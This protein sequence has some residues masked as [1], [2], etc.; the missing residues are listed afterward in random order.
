MIRPLLEYADIIFDGSTDTDLDRLESTQRQAA[1]ACSAAYKHTSH[2]KLLEELAWPLLSRRRKNHR[3]NL[4]HKIQNDLVPPYLRNSCPPLT[5]NRT[6][7]NLR[8]NMNISTPPQR[9][10]T[11]QNSFFPKTIKD[12][13]NLDRSTRLLTSTLNFKEFLKN[14]TTKKPNKL[15]HHDSSKPAIS[16]TRMRL[17]L[18]GLSSHRNDYNHIDNPKCPTCAGKTED[19]SHYF[20]LCPTYARPRPTL[21]IETCDI[22]S[23][24]GIQIDFLNKA[25]RTFYIQTLLEGSPTINMIENKLIFSHVQTFIQSS[26]RFP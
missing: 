16:Q 24:N 17:G 3:L 10:S 26:K 21:I 2:T 12:W 7:Y 4:M 20:L 19:P 23:R 1:L 11:Y 22:L 25:F 8:T 15:Y 18:S 9:T 13:N 5:R 6:Q 14:S